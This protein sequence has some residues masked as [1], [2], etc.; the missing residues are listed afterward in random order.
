M[1]VLRIALLL[2]ALI[3]LLVGIFMLVNGSLEM[4]P[5]MEQQGKVHI[6]G[7]VF[8]ICGIIMSILA[9]ISKIRK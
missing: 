6:T 3:F 1:K 8:I 2:V 4:Y 7:V 9:G 5:T